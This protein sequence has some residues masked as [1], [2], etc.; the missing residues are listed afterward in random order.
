MFVARPD[1]TIELRAKSC[2]KCHTDLSNQAGQRVD[3]NQI[4]ELPQASAQVIEVRQ[5][6]VICPECSV[7]QFEEPP[8]GLDMSRGALA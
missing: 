5:Y 3:V 6:T 4:T 2:G 8:T 1:Q 7:T